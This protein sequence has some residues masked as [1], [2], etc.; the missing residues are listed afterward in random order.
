[1]SAISFQSI[2]NKHD[3]YRGKDCKKKFNEPLTE[4][5]MKIN[6]CKQSSLRGCTMTSE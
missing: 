4:Y 3:V 2:E 5:T 1:M 6:N